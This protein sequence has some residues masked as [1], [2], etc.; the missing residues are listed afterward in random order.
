MSTGVHSKP[1]CPYCKSTDVGIDALAT[2]NA[3]TQE[4]TLE[5]IYDNGVCGSCEEI[6]KHFE[7]IEI[8]E[9]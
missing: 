5:T 8:N 2:W 9:I 4:W 7:W 3:E 1:C 6:I